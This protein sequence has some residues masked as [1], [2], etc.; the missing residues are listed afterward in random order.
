MSQA[1]K[2]NRRASLAL[3]AL[4]LLA[5]VPAAAIVIRHDRDD[6][7]YRALGAK[8]PMVG[9]LQDRVGCTLIAPR[10]V[11]TAAHTIED[12]PPFLE[13]HVSFGGRR[14]PVE[15]VIVHPQRVRGTIDSSA[16]LA[17]LELAEPVTDVEPA[18]LY[19]RGDEPG[20]IAILVG[21]GKTGTG[22]TGDTLERG[23]VRGATNK[24]E[25]ALENSLLVVFD[26]PPRGTELEGDGGGG[27]SGSAALLERDGKVY[28]AG[29][30]SFN[31][32]DQAEGTA[33]HYATFSGFARIS[34]RRQWII[35][36]LAADPPSNL[37][38]PLERLAAGAW[39]QSEFGRRAAAFFAA[40]N[41]GRESEMARFYAD[42]RPP[43]PEGKTPEERA[44]GWQELFDQYGKYEVHGFTHQG[45]TRYAVLVRSSRANLWR[46][47]MLELE[48]QAPYRVTGI[49]MWDAE[50]PRP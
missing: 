37:W 28:L 26:A 46:G 47:V 14:Y 18:L 50:A 38:P 23:Q 6:S 13:M 25:G 22:L 43:S 5:T 36:T 35:E 17:L 34:T 1:A 8:Y 20:Q 12:N 49:Q 45:E 4:A 11:A 41:A 15:K 16:D 32:G 24:I 10:W 27:D 19:D 29:V 39:P 9:Q 30:S 42:H 48:P 7:L 40:F 31:S 3:S 21:H 44:K 33:A 2:S